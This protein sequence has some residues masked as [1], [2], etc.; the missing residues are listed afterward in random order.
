MGPKLI[1]GHSEGRGSVSL[2]T[3][4]TKDFLHRFQKA[5]GHTFQERY[6]IPWSKNT[7]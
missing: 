7:P 6:N 4:G 1:T 2:S 3:P 5:F